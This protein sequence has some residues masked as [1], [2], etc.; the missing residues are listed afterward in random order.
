MIKIGLELAIQTRFGLSSR[1][2]SSKN[3][4]RMQIPLL[5]PSAKTSE[6]VRPFSLHGITDTYKSPENNSTCT[7]TYGAG[8]SN[9]TESVARSAAGCA[10]MSIPTSPAVR[11]ADLDGD[12]RAEYL[13]LSEDGA[14]TAHLNQRLPDPDPAYKNVPNPKNAL[15]HWNPQGVVAPAVD[16]GRRELVHF[17][18]LNGDGRADYLIVH[19]NGSVSAW[20]NVGSPDPYGPSAGDV[21]WRALGLVFDSIGLDG[22][23][24]RFADLNGDGLPEY[25][26]V[27]PEGAVR[28]FRNHGAPSTAANKTNNNYN[29]NSSERIRWSDAGVVASNPGLDRNK[30][31]FAD[32]KGDGRWDLVEVAGPDG[33][34]RARMNLG[35]PLKEKEKVKVRWGGWIRVVLGAG[36]GGAGD[37]PGGLNDGPG[38]L[39]DGVRLA[40]L[41]SDGRADYLHV[42]ADGR[43]RGWVNGCVVGGGLV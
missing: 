31:R 21:G 18:D 39:G 16:G 37:G 14:V 19:P 3:R 22:A 27:S 25:L 35:A 17:T 13:W 26:Y 9:G 29:N 28:A 4:V 30:V 20:L 34:V 15:I 7:C 40:D 36:A 1:A 42:G 2:S 12:G 41:N 8:K 5:E 6:S 43:V 38:G 32:L 23:G 10:N 11:F 24:V 33:S